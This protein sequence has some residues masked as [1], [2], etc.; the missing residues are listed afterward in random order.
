MSFLFFQLSFG[1]RENAIK[2]K[3]VII[4]SKLEEIPSQVVVII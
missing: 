3:A 4:I 2:E 1:V